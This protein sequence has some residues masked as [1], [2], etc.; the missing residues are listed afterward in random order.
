LVT[1]DR[2]G[3]LLVALAAAGWGTWTLFLRGRGLPPAWQSVMILS[4][5]ALFWLPAAVRASAR[6]PARSASAWALLGAAAVTDAGNYLCYFGALD[7]GPIA[8]A[9]L[10]HYLAPVVVA[11]LAPLLL[12]EALTRRTAIALAASLCGLALLV[13]G[14]GELALA[15]STTAAL[16][17]GSAIFYGL[18]TLL[19]KKLLG[20]FAASEL[21]AYHCVLSAAMVA[22]FAGPPPALS[23]FWWTPLA[24]ALLL[25]A[26]GAALFY[27]GLGAI[28][29]QR[30]AVLTYLE[31]LVAALV[32]YLFFAEPLGPAGLA[33]GALIVFSGAAVALATGRADPAVAQRPAG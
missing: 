4:V 24:G 3:T 6:R 17:A 23:A 11:V 26:V 25:G 28:P 9:V 5:I 20:P 12:R 10:T 7:R 2:I 21:L 15:S 13:L 8:L 31:P 18:N 16:G 30:A 19:T 1:K 14:D 22:I 27:L 33:G 32:G 29:A